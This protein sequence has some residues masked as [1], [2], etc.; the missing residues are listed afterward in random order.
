MLDIRT[1]LDKYPTRQ[2]FGWWPLIE[3][4]G[5]IW[6]MEIYIVRLP[7]NMC[8]VSAYQTRVAS[9]RPFISHTPNVSFVW[10]RFAYHRGL[11]MAIGNARI[12]GDWIG[13]WERTARWDQLRYIVDPL[14]TS[15]FLGMQKVILQKDVPFRTRI[16]PTNPYSEREQVE[17]WGNRIR[18]AV[19]VHIWQDFLR[20]RRVVRIQRTWRRLVLARR[21]TGT[22]PTIQILSEMCI[23]G[24][25][26]RGKYR[27]L[28]QAYICT[29]VRPTTPVC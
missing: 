5:D 26:S 1:L 27:E 2:A 22:P 14:M 11:N 9:T 25:I 8:F 16:D 4:D 12:K 21:L 17:L 3:A 15:T 24:A 18:E 29:C 6:E 7:Y 19:I 13:G 28:L 23:T 10:S 20:I